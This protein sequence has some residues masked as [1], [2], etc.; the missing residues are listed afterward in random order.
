MIK[1]YVFLLIITA[2]VLTGCGS[3]QKKNEEGDVIITT[4]KEE[5]ENMSATDKLYA[6]LMEDEE[7]D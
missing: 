4:N 5:D 1:K 7:W 3:D 6:L 2:F